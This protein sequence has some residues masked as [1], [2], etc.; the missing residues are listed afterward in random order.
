VVINSNVSM[1][2]VCWHFL[3]SCSGAA[4]LKSSL[5]LM[6]QSKCL[7]ITRT[8][9]H[10]IPCP[11]CM[12]NPILCPISDPTPVN[13]YPP[14]KG[15]CWHINFFGK[16]QISGN[17]IQPPGYPSPTQLA[18][19]PRIGHRIGY[20]I[21]RKILQTCRRSIFMS[22]RESDLYPICMKSNRESDWVGCENVRA[23]GP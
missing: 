16:L 20:G 18:V 3:G 17:N 4:Y 21:G 19:G 11:I 15:N 9:S 13:P 12:Q 10:P 7:T 6:Y 5:C 22:D 23:D 1:I 14:R 8:F 2:I